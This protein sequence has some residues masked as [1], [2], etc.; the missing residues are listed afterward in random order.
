MGLSEKQLAILRCIHNSIQEH[1]YPPT[2]REIC[3]VVGFASTSTVH[4]YLGRLEKSGYLV[5]DA[6]KTRAIE[7]SRQALDEIGVQPTEIPL[8]GRVAAGSPIL[9]VEEAS[10]YFPIPP[11]ISY[12]PSE[13]FMLEIAGDSMINIGIFDG[14]YITV[15]R[16]TTANNGDVVIAM[17]EDAEATCKT[18][19][20]QADHIILRPENDHMDDIILPNVTIL[21]KVIS[22]FRYV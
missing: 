11:G 4:G 13:L 19:Y 12:E 21:G 2:V 6:S 20:R 14:D 18:Y 10:D 22:L 15:R 1:G 3:T 8:L 9:A 5:R 16:Q 17:T 7:L